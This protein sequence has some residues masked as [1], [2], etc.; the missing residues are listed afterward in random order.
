[1]EEN[2]RILSKL[3]PKLRIDLVNWEYFRFSWRNFGKVLV[4]GIFN[5]TTVKNLAAE[6]NVP[7]NFMFI[8]CPGDHFPHNYSDFGGIRLITH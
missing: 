1:M 3:Y 5:P 4:K 7:V 8:A 2:T 6:L